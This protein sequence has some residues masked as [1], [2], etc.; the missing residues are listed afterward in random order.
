MG[1]VVGSS[2]P[3]WSLDGY[4]IGKWGAAAGSEQVPEPESDVSFR[5]MDL[6]A[7]YWLN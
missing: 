7:A 2:G 1:T 3:V 6:E 4:A 5:T